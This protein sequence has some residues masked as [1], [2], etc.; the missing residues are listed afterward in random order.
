[1]HEALKALDPALEGVAAVAWL[2]DASENADE[3]E[4]K[5]IVMFEVIPHL[6]REGWNLKG[7]TLEAIWRGERDE[8]VLLD[9][10]DGGSA[11]AVVSI[12]KHTKNLER[13]YGPAPRKD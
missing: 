9:G 7:E 1:V 10:L 11:L 3:G 4:R 2:R 12:L 5:R 6:V 8:K 13:M